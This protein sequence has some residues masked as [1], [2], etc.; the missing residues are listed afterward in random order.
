M[1]RQSVTIT[2]GFHEAVEAYRQQRGLPSWAAA[3]VELSATALGYREQAT[4]PWGGDRKSVIPDPDAPY[5][6]D[7]PWDEMGFPAPRT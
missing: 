3:L 1:P 4:R 2:E 5:P 7:D 6:E